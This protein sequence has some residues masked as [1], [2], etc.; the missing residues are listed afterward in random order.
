MRDSQELMSQM[1]DYTIFLSDIGQMS[2][3]VLLTPMT[4]GKWSVHEVVAHIMAWDVN[5]LQTAV[6]P[7]EAGAKPRIADEEDYQAL[8]ERAAAVGRQMPKDQLLGKAVEARMQLI[9]H[10]GMLSAEAFQTKQK[11]RIDTD[12]SEFLERNFVSHDKSHVSQ[13]RAYLASR[14]R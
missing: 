13:M 5:F 10:L 2:A 7:L 12:L 9:E 1:K 8:N 6:L 4:V 11:G 14:R 3:D